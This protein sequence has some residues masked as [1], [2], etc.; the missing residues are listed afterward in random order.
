MQIYKT[1]FVMFSYIYFK[2]KLTGNN[3][4]LRW[5]LQGNSKNW[6]FLQRISISLRFCNI[7]SSFWLKFAQFEDA[8]AFY[9]VNGVF[10]IDG[11]MSGWF[12]RL[13]VW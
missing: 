6:T 5:R 10:C 12:L 1:D 13:G 2:N 8:N 9:K 7:F 3:S 11:L 4:T